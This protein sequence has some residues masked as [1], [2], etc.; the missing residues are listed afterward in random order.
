MTRFEKIK[1][2]TIDEIVDYVFSNTS[3]QFCIRRN[4]GNCNDIVGGCKKYI[5][6]F[7]LEELDPT[8]KK[9]KTKFLFDGAGGFTKMKV[10][11]VCC[12]NC[13]GKGYIIEEH[14]GIKEKKTCPNCSGKGTVEITIPFK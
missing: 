13:F 3:C 5:K 12:N 11:E 4:C 14:N 2:M 1:T 7:F 6:Q 9:I 10:E 8:G